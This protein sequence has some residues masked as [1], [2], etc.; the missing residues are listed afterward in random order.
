MF[1]LSENP[2]SLYRQN[3]AE[4]I[5][6]AENSLWPDLL[7]TRERIRDEFTRERCLR[8]QRKGTRSLIWC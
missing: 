8:E 1:A 5:R 4:Q 6:R 7:F 2:G 3:A